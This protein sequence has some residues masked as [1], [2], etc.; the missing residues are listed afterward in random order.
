[1]ISASAALS[2]LLTS[3][4]VFKVAFFPPERLPFLQK[5]Q[6]IIEKSAFLLT[7]AVAKQGE[8]VSLQRFHLY[9]YGSASAAEG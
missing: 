4:A 3:Y 2:R 7:G 5:Q 8:I 9:P 1:M 6:V